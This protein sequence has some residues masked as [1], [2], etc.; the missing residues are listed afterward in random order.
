MCVITLGMYRIV[1]SRDTS[2]LFDKTFLNALGKS[3]S[4]KGT[5]HFPKFYLHF[6][7][8]YQQCVPTVY[9]KPSKK[10]TDFGFL[11]LPSKPAWLKNDHLK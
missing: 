8:K 5:N 9:F 1:T 4:T 2:L 3:M 7:Y 11:P 10:N 6:I